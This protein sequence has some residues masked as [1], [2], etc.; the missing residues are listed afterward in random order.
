MQEPTAAVDHESAKE[1]LLS[2]FGDL[3]ESASPASAAAAVTPDEPV[4]TMPYAS[5]PVAPPAPTF[6]EGESDMP[7]APRP[8]TETR[9]E[10]PEAPRTA[11]SDLYVRPMPVISD[12]EKVR[13][14]RVDTDR[15]AIALDGTFVVPLPDMPDIQIQ[16][17]ED[18][19]VGTMPDTSSVDAAWEQLMRGVS[20]DNQ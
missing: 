14:E 11:N 15:P 10:R 13:Q 3:S 6:Y 4:S 2:I 19:P 7:V 1:A 8:V 12:G 20:G 17:I 5:A 18:M 16:R 9:Y